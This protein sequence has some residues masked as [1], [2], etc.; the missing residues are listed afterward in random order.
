MN[1][2]TPDS[3]KIYLPI[4]HQERELDAKILFSLFA[5]EYGYETVLGYKEK[6]R[7]QHID[8]PQGVWI[9]HNARGQ[10]KSLEYFWYKRLGLSMVVLDEEA[11]VRQTDNLFLRKHV[12]G[13]FR[14]IDRVFAWGEN[15]RDFWLQ[16]DIV[17][18]E[19]LAVTGNPRADLLRPELLKY[20]EQKVSEIKRRWGGYVLINTNFP[21]VNNAMGEFHKFNI[22][23]KTNFEVTEDE[24]KGF[25]SHKK[26]I[27]DRFVDLIPELAAAIQPQILIIRPHPSE[28][29]TVWDERAKDIA[30]VEVVLEGGVVPWIMGS[31][32]LIHNNCTTAVEAALLEKPVASYMPVTSDRFDNEFCNSMGAELFNKEQ[33][34]SFVDRVLNGKY[35]NDISRKEVLSAHISVH[36]NK[37][38]CEYMLD[39][40]DQLLEG[41]L[42]SRKAGN[43]EIGLRNIIVDT[44]KFFRKNKK[45]KGVRSLYL[46]RKISDIETTEIVSRME[47]F[48]SCLDKFHDVEC[49][50]FGR[51][52]FVI[53]KQTY[54]E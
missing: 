32:V 40:I 25:L 33:L 42:T 14:Y 38:A 53:R 11:L 3:K 39:Q 43:I 5:A 44:A 27:F 28:D 17:S 37:F 6:L 29:R 47:K 21:T 54:A 48:K 2:L 12:P 36:K 18:A 34:F 23:D 50:N 51:D 19:K 22:S 7:Q 24:M 35:S 52:L 10:G 20:Y 8:F 41:G 4:E 49:A 26:K 45:K 16:S 1:E 31:S 9:Q 13:V 46:H 15:D 30:N